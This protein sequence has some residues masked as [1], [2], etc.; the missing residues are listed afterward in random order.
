MAVETERHWTETDGAVG[1]LTSLWRGV[2]HVAWRGWR[3]LV[4]L[5]QRLSPGFR[6]S[7]LTRRILFVNIIGLLVLVAG[8]IFLNRFRAGLIEAKVNSLVTQGEII[9]RA[10]A[11]TATMPTDRVLIDPDRFLELPSG[12]ARSGDQGLEVLDFPIDPV[13]AA[14]L[15]R[16]VTEPTG[17]RARIY[18]RDGALLLDSLTLF[19]RG[20][21]TASPLPPPGETETGLWARLSRW[22]KLTFL[23]GD[24]PPYRDIGT[25]NGKAY[26]E[27]ALALTGSTQRIARVNDKG[28]MVL[29]VAVPIQRVKAVL[30]VLMLSTRGG[31]IDAIVAAER[32]GI[33][34]VSL[35]A[36]AVTLFLSLVLAGTIAAPLRRL[37]DA[38]NKVRRAGKTR[39]EIPDFSARSDEIGRLSEALREMTQ[40]LYDRI[41]AIESF[42][43]DVSHELK[44]PLASLKSAV[45]VLPKV[46][47][48]DSRAEL[49]RVIDH[50]VR[51]LDRLIT[52]ISAA[53]RLDA[54]L[55]REEEALVMVDK[56]LD[57]V[58]ATFNGIQRD[59]GP[60]LRLTVAPVPA[61]SDA[62][63][64]SGFEGRLAQVM[65]NLLDNAISFSPED[66]EVRIF[67]ES[68]GAEVEIR[69]EDDG[70]GIPPDNLERIFERFY[71]DRP[72]K[73]GFGNNSG[74]GL[75]ISR[76]IVTAHRGRIW[77]ENR[78]EAGSGPGGEG[79]GRILGARFIIRLPRAANG[80]AA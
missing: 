51:R 14:P 62:Y 12:A 39:V 38:A 25:A 41:D 43:A 2:R 35:F 61:G 19:E 6:F 80:G 36:L 71:T 1:W 30:G 18:D 48:D 8:I 46:R 33:I 66:G 69:V 23:H 20:R 58:V 13:K 11:S 5:V 40:S 10:I 79:N 26:P 17:T 60:R 53:S 65:N 76:Q 29:V 37:A 63:L 73:E 32:W 21:I 68:D 3:G 22:F 34:R 27:V 74:L 59:G 49:L 15:L 55:A 57:V 24:L 70:P 42:A 78:Y 52:D 50:D 9:A 7:S 47:K 67:L 56:L 31:E 16:L 72:E 77:A 4:R 75:N 45:D 28:E 64:V 54:E 44:N